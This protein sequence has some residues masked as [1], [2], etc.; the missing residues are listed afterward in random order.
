MKGIL[1]DAD[2]DGPLVNYKEKGNKVEF[3][4]MDEV[5]GTDT[6]KLVTMANG[7]SGT[8]DTDYLVRSD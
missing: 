3:I 4:G 2:F 5:E 7:G 1:G 6:Y 8:L